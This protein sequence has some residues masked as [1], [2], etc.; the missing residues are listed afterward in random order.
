MYFKNETKLLQNKQFSYVDD[1]TMK[2]TDF[3]D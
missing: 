1:G 2:F 3:I